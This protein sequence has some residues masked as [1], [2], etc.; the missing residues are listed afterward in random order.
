MTKR[1]FD[2]QSFIGWEADDIAKWPANSFYASEWVEVRK[3]L[4]YAKLESKLV[5]TWWTF[6][7]NISCIANLAE[8]WIS[9]GWIVVCTSSGN[10]YLNGV[11]KNTFAS[12]TRVDGIGVMTNNTWSQFVY[13]YSAPVAW[14]WVIH[15]SNSSLST[16]N[17]A[18]KSYTATWTVFNDKD[19][20]QV[21]S[22]N[23]N[24]YAAI[25]NCIVELDKSEVVSNALVLPTEES[26]YWFTQFQNN[27][28]IYTNI[29]NS[30]VQYFWNWT[31][32]LPFYRQI[33]N[34][35]RILGVVNDGWNDYAVL[36]YDRYY[37]DLYLIQGTQKSEVRV[38]KEN[39]SWARFLRWNMT[40][41]QGIVYISGGRSG[42]WE[43]VYT[44]GNYYPGTNKSLV[45]LVSLTD[46]ILLHA[47][48]S[49]YTYFT[50]AS[51]NKVYKIEN[52]TT[53][54][55]LWYVDSGNI[56]TLMQRG[57]MIEEMV[58][59]KIKIALKLQPNTRILVYIRS[60]ESSSYILI[61]DLDFATYQNKKTYTMR[62][63]EI[64]QTA[65]GNITEFQLKIE[66]VSGSDGS[67]NA[68][69]PS[70]WRV[71]VYADT[72]NDN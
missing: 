54:S 6:S 28:K 18:Y 16:F 69:T 32:V 43:G 48:D 44:Y 17:L 45:R 8:L 36:W 67:I 3:D 71:V 19:E 5:D 38:D 21:I 34:N 13:Y 65:L 10:V 53:P 29:G 9:W 33:W 49:Q 58:I 23:G 15:R 12:N 27:F 14:V 4:S 22:N 40:I 64:S 25:N 61:K 26:I 47:H 59:D 62:H 70:V 50:T 72:V 68:Y 55:N 30:W 66:L 2:I 31:D 11:L 35:S 7:G 56:Q 51:D 20:I 39:A 57:Q 46:T 42:S 41:R 52:D 24:L 1:V 63:S 37:S 60:D